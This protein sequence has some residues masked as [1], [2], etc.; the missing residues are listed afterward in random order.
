MRMN[1]TKITIAASLLLTLIGCNKSQ[2]SSTQPTS[3]P[4]TS[5]NTPQETNTSP[6]NPTIAT[7]PI[8]TNSPQ[9]INSSPSGSQTAAT[10]NPPPTQ[11]QLIWAEGIGPAKVGMTLGQ[12]KQILAGKAEFTVKS[13]FMVDFDAIAVSQQGQE[14]FYILYPAMSRLADTDVIEALVTNNPNYRTTQGVGP[15]TPI[16]QAEAVYGQASLTYNTLNESREYVKFAKFNT[17]AI[18]FRT[19]APEGKNFAGIY[20]V[21]KGESKQTKQFQ[22]TATIRLVEVYCR[23]NCPLPAP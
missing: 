18:A 12:L 2:I 19:K 6:V 23:N 7:S 8:T 21:S 4:A 5:T 16:K 3:L 13:P 17:T 11:N 1:F 10:P 22:K 15:G 9:Q 14:Q 20:P